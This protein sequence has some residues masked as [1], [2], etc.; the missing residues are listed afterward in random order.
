MDRYKIF[1]DRPLIN[2]NGF[3]AKQT[4]TKIFVIGAFSTWIW[5]QKREHD[6]KLFD[7]VIKLFEKF[8][9]YLKRS[10][11][12][13]KCNF[14]IWNIQFLFEKFNFY[15]KCSI[16]V[17]K[18]N[19]FIWNVKFLFE[20]FNFYLKC[21]IFVGKCNF[22]IWNVKTK[23]ENLKNFCEEVILDRNLPFRPGTKS[24]SQLQSGYKKR[25]SPQMG[26]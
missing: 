25:F 10:I 3:S 9:F 21:S 22:F 14:F 13:G 1:W 8:N 23:L 15:L 12:V 26:Y 5:S 7:Y 18:C 24:S 16:F 11:F 2:V 6:A 17:G 20:K 4:G 19:F